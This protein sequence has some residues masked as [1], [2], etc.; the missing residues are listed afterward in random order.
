MSYFRVQCPLPLTASLSLRKSSCN[1]GKEPWCSTRPR[2][3]EC[4]TE[5]AFLTI[6]KTSAAYTISRSWGSLLDS[7]RLWRTIWKALSICQACDYFSQR[8]SPFSGCERLTR[9][10]PPLARTIPA[11]LLRRCLRLRNSS[12]R[13][14]SNDH[15]GSSIRPPHVSFRMNPIAILS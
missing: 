8:Q 13:S 12:T 9:Y 11:S 4:H 5:D 1:Q 3:S 2:F 15:P 7:S 10:L 14:C 6:H